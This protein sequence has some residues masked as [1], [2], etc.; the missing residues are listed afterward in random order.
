MPS[1][2]LALPRIGEGPH[3]PSCQVLSLTVVVIVLAN[4]RKIA[5][6]R[7][8]FLQNANSIVDPP[9]RIQDAVA[10]ARTRTFL[11]FTDAL[12]RG[13]EPHA[14]TVAGL[15]MFDKGHRRIGMTWVSSRVPRLTLAHQVSV[16]IVQTLCPCA[17]RQRLSIVDSIGGARVCVR[18]RFHARR[19]TSP[20]THR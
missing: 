12:D 16:T 3:R 8:N 17:S 9:A 4:V 10:L 2:P 5:V 18:T 15:G 1:S 14:I 11:C 19:R 6:H 13:V 7:G 20:G